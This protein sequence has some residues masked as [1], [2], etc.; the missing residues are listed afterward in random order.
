[1]VEMRIIRDRY[2]LDPNESPREGGMAE[3]YLA[4]D[5]QN[6]RKEVAVKLF[7]A[8]IADERCVLEAFSRECK[9]LEELN[10][11]PNVVQLIDFGTDDQTGR[12]YIVLDWLN[13]NLVDYLK[14]NPPAGWDDFYNEFGQPI[15]DALVFAY[16]RD[17]LHRDVKPQNILLGDDRRVQVADFSISKFKKYY[18]PDGVT[19]AHFKTV[20][21]SPEIDSSEFADTRDVYGYAVLALECLSTKPFEDYSNVYDFLEDDFDAPPEIYNIFKKALERE[22]ENRR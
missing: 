14:A 5:M 8:G 15:L 16:S 21:Y 19:L 4:V 7:R 10:N 2:A 22:P 13:D 9:S 18:R 12:K 3:V 17:I 11:H 20:P 1:M 6:G